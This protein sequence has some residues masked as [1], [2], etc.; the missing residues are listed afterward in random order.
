LNKKDTFFLCYTSF[1][2][3]LVF[4]AIVPH[5][6]LLLPSIGKE[7]VD[8]LALTR[9]AFTI[10]GQALQKS[11]AETVM[12]I[13]PHGT[14][15]PEVLCMST[16]TPYTADFT[17]FGDIVTKPTWEK[18]DPVLAEKIRQI[19][20]ARRVPMIRCNEETLDYGSAIPLLVLRDYMPNISIL[21]I[22][23]GDLPV[24]E[25]FTMGQILSESL[26][27]VKRRVA[28][29][30]SV[31]LSHCA[32]EDSPEGCSALGVS[33]DSMVR[34]I[35]ES[36]NNKRILD[37]STEMDTEARTCATRPLALLFGLMD[38]MHAPSELLSYEKPFGT[39]YLIAKYTLR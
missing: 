22:L 36:G 30:C 38:T 9:H 16:H 21:P 15:V 5:S 14:S 19:A 4:S 29:L 35:V 8:A 12:I 28:V 26:H 27:D 17:I 24:L 1:D 33:Y 25:Y 23:T 18:S 32:S 6:P 39:G 20:L 34:E 3:S 2:M 10:I 37:V 13:S 31:D 7:N 11:G